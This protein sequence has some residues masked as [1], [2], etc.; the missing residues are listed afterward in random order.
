M[1]PHRSAPPRPGRSRAAAPR[2][3]RARRP[4]LLRTAALLVVA[5]GTAGCGL[6]LESPP[7]A[8]PSPDAVEQVR[9]RTVDDALDLAQAATAV[10]PTVTDEP[11]RAVLDDV[12]A[13]SARHAEELGGRYVSGL[14]TP[15]VSAT[16]TAAPTVT[17]VTGLLEEL[18]ADAAR[19]AKDADE[20]P[21]GELARLV[22]SVSVAR[23]QL[24]DRLAAAGALPRP[25]PTAAPDARADGATPTDPAAPTSGP[26]DGTGPAEG[27]G[28]TDGTGATTPP[29]GAAELALAHDEAAWTST[30]LAARADDAARAGLLEAAA[31][32]R[33][34]SDV[35]ARTAG[36]AGQPSDPRRAAYALPAGVD[37]PVVVESLP[38]ALEQAVADAAASAVVGAP[39]GTRAAAVAELRTAT[40]AAVARGAAPVP[41]PGMPELATQP[42]G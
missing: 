26:T 6:R 18:A 12:A 11:V 5:L 31:R 14:P 10:A 32:H 19:A 7:P 4:P 1:L 20:V 25:A 22:A 35:W 34:A 36:V 29:E 41:F 13:F 8:E 38:R 33:A 21:D 9:A 30:V 39:T 40:A 2:S 42:V 17:D 16:T 28:A 27:T 24:T 15:T 23:D 3:A 37:D